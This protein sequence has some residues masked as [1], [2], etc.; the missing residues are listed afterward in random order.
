VSVRL[1]QWKTPKGATKEAWQIL[2]Y[3]RGPDGKQVVVDRTLKQATKK[4]AERIEADI[5]RDIREG[6]HQKKQS[7]ANVPTVQDFAPLIVG[8]VSKR[9]KRTATLKAA[10]QCA[11]DVAV[12]VHIVPFFGAMRLDDV[13]TAE[14]ERFKQHVSSGRKPKTINNILSVLNT[15]F[16]HAVESGALPAERRPTVSLVP[17]QAPECISDDKRYDGDTYEWFIEEASAL[18]THVELT[19]LL[20]G[21]AGLR[22]GEII[23]LEWDDIDWKNEVLKIERSVWNG[24]G[25]DG[26]QRTV[27]D[28]PKSGKGREVPMTERLSRVLNQH[29]QRMTNKRVLYR[30]DGTDVDRDTLTSWIKR[31]ERRMDAENANGRMHI[32]RHTFCS[33]LAEAGAPVIAIKEVAG[34][35][36]IATTQ[37]YMHAGR[38]VRRA[39]I[40]L[41]DAAHGKNMARNSKDRGSAT[42]Q[43]SSGGSARES[44]PP[45]TPC[46]ATHSF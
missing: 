17:V 8:Y 10:S 6:T 31:L 15:M 26:E 30:P 4:E 2:V 23:G 7:L 25:P 37:L 45:M 34:H 18:G 16:E 20:A 3:E 33:R 42:K 24:R 43:A 36:S 19:V 11:K 46:D 38:E 29:P 27:V 13:T 1:R 44:N 39:A 35:T 22:Q 28:T 12:R 14:V 9:R 40:E 5:R 21:D 32:F 41:L